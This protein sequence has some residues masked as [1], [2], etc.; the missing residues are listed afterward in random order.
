MC[1]QGQDTTGTGI[2]FTM[3]TLATHPEVQR[4]AYEEVCCIDTFDPNL[5]LPYLEAVIKE[6]LRIYPSVPSFSR[7][8]NET[9]II[10]KLLAA[11]T[12]HVV[13][14]LTAHFPNR[15]VHHSRQ[16]ND[17]HSWVPCAPRGEILSQC[18]IV[19]ARTLPAR[20]NQS[21]CERHFRH[22]T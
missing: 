9:T 13:N 20:R 21:V 11:F 1:I 12:L 19:P 18:R 14:I 5:S 2:A 4:L 15:K 10:G 22:W 17:Q 6:T 7:E 3:Y 16:R 8:T